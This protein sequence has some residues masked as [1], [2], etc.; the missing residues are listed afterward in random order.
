MS[1]RTNKA[2]EKSKE[3]GKVRVVWRIASSWNDEC[4]TR[5]VTCK[6]PYKRGRR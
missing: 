4:R 6:V 3:V 1:D 2:R 5:S